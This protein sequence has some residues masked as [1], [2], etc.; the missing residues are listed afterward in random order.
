MKD[1]TKSWF[2]G[3]W[4]GTVLYTAALF[5][6]YGVCKAL[7]TY[8]EGNKVLEQ[9]ARMC[10]ERVLEK[11]GRPGLSYADPAGSY[12]AYFPSHKLRDETRDAIAFD[13]RPYFCSRLL[14]YIDKDKSTDVSLE[15]IAEW[16]APCKQ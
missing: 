1:T 15:E 8:H 7:P 2:K 13:R 3:Y 12:T 9:R 4:T 14:A 11:D 10:T 5:G 6:I 16:N